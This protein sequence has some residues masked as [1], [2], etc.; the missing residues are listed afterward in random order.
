MNLKNI[1]YLSNTDYDTLVSDHTVTI[2]G[3]TI[4]YSDD[5]VYITPD[6][7]A[8][9][10]NDGLMSASDKVNLDQVVDIATNLSETGTTASGQ[11]EIKWTKL[12]VFTRSANTVF[13]FE[14]PKTNC[15][16]EYKGIITN[17][18]STDAITFTFNGVSNIICNDENCIVTNA[19]NS[20]IVLPAGVSIEFS[21]MNGKM[22]A[23]N[24]NH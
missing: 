17:S 20:T 1:I 7:I 10:S 18:H 8:S 16:N 12:L 22:A 19:T 13:S 2:N 21:I 15:L 24:W 5:D 4:T 3:E 14:T 6:R 23:I 11:G 9:S